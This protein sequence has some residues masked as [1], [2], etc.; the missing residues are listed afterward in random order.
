MHAA[1]FLDRDDTLIATTD[2]TADSAAPGDLFEPSRVRLLPTVAESLKRLADAGFALVVVSN[3]GALAAGRCSLTEAEATND[4]MRALL[5]EESVTLA[6]VY[7][8]PRRPGGTV[9]RFMH[10]PDVWRK[11]GPGMFLAAA[12]ELGVDL[13]RSWMIGDAERDLVAGQVAGIAPWRCVRVGAPDVPDMKSACDRV[14]GRPL[15]R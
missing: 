14:L 11:P 2:A 9:E 1:V 7:M 15:S 13:D 8:A 4:R 3:Q 10:D 12:R 6:G 5:A